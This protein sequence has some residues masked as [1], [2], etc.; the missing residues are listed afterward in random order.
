MI[1][2]TPRWRGEQ[3]SH[4]GGPCPRPLN[5][6]KG[7]HTPVQRANN[8]K[9]WGSLPAPCEQRP[10]PARVDDAFRNGTLASPQDRWLA[11]ELSRISPAAAV[12]VKERD[13]FT[14][15][16]VE[17]ALAGGITQFLDLGCGLADSSA[18]YSAL[19][20]TRSAGG[21]LSLV[22]VD[23]DA[24]VLDRNRAWLDR[25]PRRDHLSAHAVRGNC[26]AVATMLN[27]LGNAGILDL[28]RPVCDLLTDRPDPAAP[29]S[30]R[31]HVPHP[32]L[33]LCTVESDPSC[34]RSS[35]PANRPLPPR[36]RRRRAVNSAPRCAA[37]CGVRAARNQESR[38]LS[39]GPWEDPAA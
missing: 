37:S 2:A 8:Q 10:H 23:N 29:A 34:L 21:T 39:A 11:A 36:D 38:R 5:C 18:A 20:G 22:L 24:E 1:P 13:R 3:V 16:V 17:D 31:R 4:W 27:D 6:C 14:T 9:H 28:D 33:V 26:F 7:L 19:A 32:P 30:P 15:R 12:A 25:S 35:R